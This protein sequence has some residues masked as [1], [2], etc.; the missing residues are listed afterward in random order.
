MV[1][2]GII[3]SPPPVKK[4]TLAEKKHIIKN[5]NYLLTVYNQWIVLNSDIGLPLEEST[6]DQF[7]QAERDRW[8]PVRSDVALFDQPPT[9]K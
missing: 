6:L 4:Q 9:E 5:Y 3:I 8:N 1:E 2:T 7:A